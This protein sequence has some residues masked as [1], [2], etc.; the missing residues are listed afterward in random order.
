MRK[1]VTL[2]LAAGF[3][4]LVSCE[5]EDIAFDPYADAFIVTKTVENEGQVDTL[6]GLALHAFGN[7]AMTSV[8]VKLTND[9]EASFALEPYFNNSYDFYYETP[10]AEFT[11]EKPV[12]G[13]YNFT[14]LAESGEEAELSDKLFEDAI[15]PTDLIEAS[16]DEEKEETT[17]TWNEI[18]DADYFVIKV[19]D[20][21][22]KLVF[23]PSRAIGEGD[24][25]EYS[26]KASTAG[27]LNG[28]IPAV[29]KNFRVELDAYMYESGQQGIN[30]QTKAINEISIIWGE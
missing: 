4:G 6:Y 12:L 18:E 1:I 30:L 17:L 2:A 11:S 20:E 21:E 16:Y 26:F 27:W 25:T 24:M 8:D 10:E 22:D 3:L 29:G 13:D 23:S 9:A 7:K 5:S 28:T 19:Y 15:Y 14:V